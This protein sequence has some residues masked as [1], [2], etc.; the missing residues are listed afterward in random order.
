MMSLASGHTLF[1]HYRISQIS[2]E[3]LK[4]VNN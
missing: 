3:L 1:I 4:N 2:F